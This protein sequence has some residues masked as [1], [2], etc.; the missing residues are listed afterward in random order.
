MPLSPVRVVRSTL[1]LVKAPSPFV[2][3]AESWQS[4]LISLLAL[5]LPIGGAFFPTKFH[6]YFSFQ[7]NKHE[8]SPW[9]P[10]LAFT[11]SA[12]AQ[13]YVYFVSGS[14]GFIKRVWP[15]I[16]YCTHVIVSLE[17]SR[18][19]RAHN[20]YRRAWTA[21]SKLF[22]TLGLPTESYSD[23]ACGGAT[24]N[25]FLVGFSPSLGSP[26]AL[27]ADVQRSLRHY[28]NGGVEGRFSRISVDAFTH[29]K[30]PPRRVVNFDDCV[31]V[32]GLMPGDNPTALVLCPSYFLKKHWVKRRLLA[33]E[34]MGLFQIPSSMEDSLSEAVTNCIANGEVLPFE[35]SL[36]PV[37]CTALLRQL[38]GTTGGGLSDAA[39][40][41]T[42]GL[43][44]AA[45]DVNAAASDAAA[46]ATLGGASLASAIDNAGDATLD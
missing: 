46:D 19:E 7:Q 41:N 12:F 34:L 40:A 25:R 17:L 44:D 31:R 42:G 29:I 18:R 30:D 45:D 24:T 2:V 11:S 26:P 14:R 37:M 27:T 38:W 21:G 4:V 43:S 36:T 1:A 23:R 15:K 8:V 16:K 28:V 6:H 13:D 33:S 9:H 3:V 5:K 35:C 20:T 22:Q 10:T 32:E 39:D